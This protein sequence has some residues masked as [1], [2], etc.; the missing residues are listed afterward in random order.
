MKDEFNTYNSIRREVLDCYFEGCRS[1]AKLG[2]PHAE[3]LGYTT[4]QYEGVFESPLTNLMKDVVVL[5]LIGPWYPDIYET[6]RRQ[7]RDE[8]LDPLVVAQLAG[9]PAEERDEFLVDLMA[10][11]ITPS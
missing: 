6:M 9:L 3:A 11:D 2:R 10:C 7:V 5:I 4:L 1:M 8:L